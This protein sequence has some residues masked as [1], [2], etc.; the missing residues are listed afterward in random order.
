VDE[1]GDP[2]QWSID[3]KANGSIESGRG[4]LNLLYMLVGGVVLASM[5]RYA[6]VELRRPA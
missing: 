6:V 1:N 5:L 2:V 3:V 4:F